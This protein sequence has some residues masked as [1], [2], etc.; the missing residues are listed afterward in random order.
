MHEKIIHHRGKVVL[1][2][3]NRWQMSGGGYVTTANTTPYNSQ[4]QAIL[5]FYLT[6]TPVAPNNMDQ[7]Y[8]ICRMR[9]I[10]LYVL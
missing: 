8:T 2:D 7:H 6:I 10:N 4:N 1:G 3:K 5:H 9:E